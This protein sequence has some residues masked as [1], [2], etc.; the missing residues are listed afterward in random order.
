MMIGSL[1]ARAISICCRR[2]LLHVA[3]RVIV[4]VVE[5]D[6]A[7]GD[8]LGIAGQSLQFVEVGWLG[9]FG[10]MRMNAYGRVNPVVLLRE[11]DGAIQRAGP[12]PSPLPMASMR[13]DAGFLGAG[14]DVS[15]IG[16]EALVFEMA[17]RVGIHKQ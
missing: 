5:A 12:G 3:R 15:A 10:L 14:E 4:K 7:P 17:V 2:P 16:V 9:E 13:G 11:F 6:F 8:D 1:A